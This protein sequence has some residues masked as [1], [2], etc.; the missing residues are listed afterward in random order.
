M[1]KEIYPSFVT[2][3]FR[4]NKPSHGGEHRTFEVMISTSIPW[5]SSLIVGLL[6]ATM[7]EKKS[8]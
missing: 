1:T 2:D 6:A 7:S 5:F 3:I 4:N 8:S